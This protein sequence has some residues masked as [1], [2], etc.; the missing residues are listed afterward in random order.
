MTTDPP[1]RCHVV[2]GKGG[3]GKT[4]VAAALALALAAGGRHTLLVET[5]GRQGIAQLFDTPPLPYE[6]RRVA[7]ARGG[8]EVKA[9]AIDLDEALLE[10]LELFYSMKRAGRALR[11][12]GAIDFATTIAPGLRD[13]LLT[14]KIKEAVTRKVD[15][16]R[17]YDAV[18]VDA[19]PTGRITRFLNVT[20]EVA[21]LARSGPIKAQSDGVMAVLRSPQTAVH[22]VTLLEE[23]PVQ[24]TADAIA[25]LTATGL[26]VGSVLVNMATEPLLPA[27]S[28]ARAAEGRLTAAELAPA[29]A[30]GGLPDDPAVAAGLAEEAVEH[31]RRW[32][33]QDA[34]RGRVAE[35]GRPVTELPLVTGPVDLGALQELA[36]RLEV[37]R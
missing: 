1:V 32:Q 21:G 18:V 27:A 3:T 15:G 19:P 10:Y 5:E 29:L 8:G 12:M 11:R 7:V 13:V 22:L 34:L 33:S 20:D 23:M 25:E 35:L 24:E 6:E 37:L 36:S 16:R 30:A 4:T 2:T 28:L 9:L 14:G 26:P 31:A 17:V